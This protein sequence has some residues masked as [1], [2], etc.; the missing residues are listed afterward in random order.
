[1]ENPYITL[2]QKYAALFAEGRTFPCGGIEKLNLPLVSGPTVLWFAPH[3]DDECIQGGWALRLRKEG[4][5]VI[6]VAVTLGSNK[7]R[8]LGR[9]AE[10]K[11]ACE[12]MNFGFH[13]S[14]P[15]V[16][17][18]HVTKKER[19]ANP[20][21]WQKKVAV[22]KDIITKY[23]PAIIGVPH[24]G[25][26]N[27]THIGTHYVVEDAVRELNYQGV[28]LETEFWGA[29][30]KPNL[31][32][33]LQPEEVAALMT[34]ISFHVGEVSRNPYHLSLPGWMIDNVRR[35]GEIVGGQG[36]DVP[37]FTFAAIYNVSRLVNGE[38]VPLFEKGVML[39]SEKSL[40]ELLLK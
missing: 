29:M 23:N 27:G 24:K 9:E 31:M 8:Q 17:L 12:Y 33:E 22:V 18:E 37:D 21:E 34:G 7:A 20:E 5:N 39:P 19:E 6:D 26:W 16:G 28:F 32:C 13:V 38:F 15:G 3:P 25:D 10:L 14:V 1:M 40:K 30:D 2:A 4:C 11:N 35:G 36:G